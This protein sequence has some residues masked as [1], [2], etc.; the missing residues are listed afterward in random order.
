MPIYEYE[1]EKCQKITEKWQNITEDPLTTCPECQGLLKKVISRTSFHLKG[2]GWFADGY[3]NG[4]SAPEKAAAPKSD[5]E[6][7][8][9][10]TETKSTETKSTETNTPAKSPEPATQK[11]GTDAP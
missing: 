10:G 7:S 11:T 8:S 4:K 2:G 3:S 9:G 1:C 6:G 5:G